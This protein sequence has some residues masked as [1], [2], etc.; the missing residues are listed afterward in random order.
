MELLLPLA[1]IVTEFLLR[2]TGIGFSRFGPGFSV[3]YPS[4]VF[5]HGFHLCNGIH[6]CSG[7]N[8]TNKRF[9]LD[10]GLLRNGSRLYRLSQL[11]LSLLKSLLGLPDSG[12]KLDSQLL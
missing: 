8:L 1:E 12:L 10:P 4:L 11:S 5:F 3:R 6:L 2:L 9:G 7:A